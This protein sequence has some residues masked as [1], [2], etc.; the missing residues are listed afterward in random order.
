[1]DFVRSISGAIEGSRDMVGF[2]GS[3][4]ACHLGCD[5]GRS[6]EGAFPDESDG[7]RGKT[8]ARRR[9]DKMTNG[10]N[11]DHFMC[12]ICAAESGSGAGPPPVHACKCSRRGEACAPSPACGALAAEGRGEGCGGIT[13]KAPAVF[14]AS[15]RPLPSPPPQSEAGEGGPRGGGDLRSREEGRAGRL[16][17]ETTPPWQARRAAPAMTSPIRRCRPA[18]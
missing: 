1:M 10:T 8:A 2:R 18:P 13:E 12:E 6:R 11:L 4:G 17:G 16:R 5:F 7:G 3:Q 14:V 15:Q 9:D